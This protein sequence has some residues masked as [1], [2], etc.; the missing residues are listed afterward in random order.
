MP[1]LGG[2]ERWDHQ[3]PDLPVRRPVRDDVE[4]PA[5]DG[6][7]HLHVVGIGE[8][9]HA[10]VGVIERVRAGED[11]LAFAVR[12]HR[13]GEHDHALGVGGQP[14]GRVVEVLV[15]VDP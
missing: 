2:E 13:V 10:D 12:L 7:H 4:H 3:R 6:D 5:D 14:D 15:G 11:D 9:V 8:V 1:V